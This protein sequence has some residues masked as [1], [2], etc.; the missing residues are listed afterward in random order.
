MVRG[1]VGIV[2]EVVTGIRLANVQLLAL[3]PQISGGQK[4]DIPWCSIDCERRTE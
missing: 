2:L 4:G 1:V 3:A